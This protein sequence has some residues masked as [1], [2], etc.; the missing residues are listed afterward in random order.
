M[1]IAS[2]RSQYKKVRYC[3][4]PTIWHS[5]KGNYGDSLKKKKKKAMVAVHGRMNREESMGFLEWWNYFVWHSNGRYITL[6]GIR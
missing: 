5:G 1:H 6:L 3:M 2:E 4:I